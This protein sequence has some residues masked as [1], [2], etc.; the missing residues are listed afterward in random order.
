MSPPYNLT[1]GVVGGAAVAPAGCRIPATATR[2]RRLLQGHRRVH[3]VCTGGILLL[4]VG[5]CGGGKGLRPP[6]VREVGVAASGH[7]FSGSGLESRGLYALCWTDESRPDPCPRQGS[8]DSPRREPRP[9]LL[10]EP[11]RE[12]WQNETGGTSYAATVATAGTATV[13]VVAKMVGV[14]TTTITAG[15]TAVVV[16]GEARR[17]LV[18]LR[19]PSR[20]QLWSTTGAV[21]RSSGGGNGGRRNG[22]GGRGGGRLLCRTPA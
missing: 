9:C 19:A 20:G 14:A 8:A 12:S 6:L 1:K 11:R 22:T 16:A 3:G 2:E 10:A 5:D 7:P 13:G 15:V 18:W 4:S 17:V 21:G